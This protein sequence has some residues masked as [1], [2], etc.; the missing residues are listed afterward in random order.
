[1]NCKEV[2]CYVLIRECC[3]KED[4][5][6]E[7]GYDGY[8]K[9][10]FVLNGKSDIKTQ[11]ELQL[12]RHLFMNEECVNNEECNNVDDVISINMNVNV[13]CVYYVSKK[14]KQILDEILFA[15]ENHITH[16]DIAID[17]ICFDTNDNTILNNEIILTLNPQLYYYIIDPTSFITPF[18]GTC[19]TC[20]KQIPYPLYTCNICH[21][22]SYCS[23]DCA[24]TDDEHKLFQELFIKYKSTSVSVT[25][26]T[27]LTSTT[28]H[29]L[30]PSSLALP[31]LTGLINLGNTCY[32]NSALQCLAH[33]DELVKYFLMNYHHKEINYTSEH[34]SKGKM[35]LAFRNVITMLWKSRLNVVDPLC[36]INAFIKKYPRFKLG[37]QNDA[38]EILNLILDTLHEDLNRIQHKQYI[39]LTEK[40]KGESD[41]MASDR[42]WCNHISRENSIIVDLFH[43]QYKSMIECTR[44]RNRSVTFEPFMFLSLSIPQNQYKY[45]IKLF[46]YDTSLNQLMYDEYVLSIFP[47]TTV[48]NI[49]DKINAKYISLYSRTL[50]FEVILMSK[51]KVI[52]KM[53]NDNEKVFTYLERKEEICLFA[54]TSFDCFNVYIYPILNHTNTTTTSSSSSHNDITFVS[55][56]IPISVTIKLTLHDLY[57]KVSKL[58]PHNLKLHIYH[59]AN[60]NTAWDYLGPLK[61]FLRNKCEFCNNIFFKSFCGLFDNQLKPTDT[62]QT[63]LTQMRNN[64]INIFLAESPNIERYTEIYKG[65]NRTLA[66]YINN[67]E[68]LITLSNKITVDDMM[69]SF[70]CKEKLEGDNMWFCKECNQLQLPSTR[71]NIYRP[72]KYLI[73]HLKRF[74]TDHKLKTAEKNSIVVDY[75]I[76]NFDM[77]RYVIGPHKDK[78]VYDL[79]G[80]IQHFGNDVNSGHYIAKCKHFDKW[81]EFNDSKVNKIEYL[82]NSQAYLLFYKMK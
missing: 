70:Q 35:L 9:V 20:H 73:I 17:R 2:E 49:K 60:T 24:I 11:V 62:I 21:Y 7:Y 56:P 72:P 64:R 4:K 3:R 32:F 37:E 59:N 53:L 65:M 75:E 38:H 80:M 14:Q 30:L 43:G 58:F 25:I 52:E 16:Y 69:E 23:N 15:F 44:C 79:Y 28:L 31:G 76:N 46:Q 12:K 33:T 61:F 13:N 66:S 74:K 34:G 51:D 6:C 39:A 68:P 29:T 36:F 5:S 1:M 27:S 41:I 10:M 18:N 78:A 48:R 19:K 54:K 26:Y 81:Y 40:Y 57:H 55:Y 42:W 77:R 47:N 63:M 8:K 45:K 82:I 22:G 50:A 71:I 67:I